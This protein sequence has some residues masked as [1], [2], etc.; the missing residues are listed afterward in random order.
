MATNKPSKGRN[1]TVKQKINLAKKVCDLYSTDKFTLDECLK[2]NA[3]NSRTTWAN[4]VNQIEQIEQLYNIAIQEKNNIYDHRIVEKAKTNLE[5]LIEG[6]EY[7]EVKKEGEVVNGKVVVQKV[8]STT[9]HQ[10]PSLGAITFALTNRD[11]NNF[12]HGVIDRDDSEVIETIK[13]VVV[14]IQKSKSKK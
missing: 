7:D 6:W 11:K 2:A 8:T 12:N 3:I 10:K 5:K 13:D 4:W 9:K 14:N 1:L